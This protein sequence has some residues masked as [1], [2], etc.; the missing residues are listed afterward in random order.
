MKKIADL[1]EGELKE[2]LTLTLENL[3]EISSDGYP[4][5]IDSMPDVVLEWWENEKT[6]G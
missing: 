4:G 3:E 1:S 6:K 5:L 2:L